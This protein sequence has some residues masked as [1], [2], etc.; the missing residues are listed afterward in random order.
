M[1]WGGVGKWLRT[2]C[3]FASKDDQLCFAC[4]SEVCFLLVGK[5]AVEHAAEDGALDAVWVV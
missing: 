4:E 1:G 5:S 2:C 3:A